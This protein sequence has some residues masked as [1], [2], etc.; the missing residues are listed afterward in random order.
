MLQ[1]CSGR[2]PEALQLPKLPSS[3]VDISTKSGYINGD[4]LLPS[5]PSKHK[6]QSIA[7]GN[8]QE[9]RR[10]KNFGRI[11]ARVKT[12]DLQPFSFSKDAGMREV[13]GSVL[14]QKKNVLGLNDQK[15]EVE[16]AASELLGKKITLQLISRGVDPET[17][18]GKKSNI[19]NLEGWVLKPDTLLADKGTTYSVHFK[20][21]EDFGTPGAFLM[22]NHHPSEFFLKSLTLDMPDKTQIHFI[23]NSWVFNEKTYEEPRVFFS[24]QVYLPKDT[25]AGLQKLRVSELNELRGDG[26]GERKDSDRQYDYDV[27]NDLGNPDKGTG[28]ARPV[29]GGSAERPYPRRCRTGR[30]PCKN[31][32]TCESA[33]VGFKETYVPR[34]E[35][36]SRE[37]LTD[38]LSSTLKSLGMD[39]IPNLE[40]YFQ[41]R[42][43]FH[44]FKEIDDFYHKG[45]DLSKIISS[46]SMPAEKREAHHKTPLEFINELTHPDL[47][48]TGTLRY[49]VPQVLQA[50][51]DAWLLD[52][53]FARQFIAGM[54]PLSIEGLK[55]FPPVSKLDPAIYGD[56]TSAITES[57][58]VDKLEGLSVKEALK[59]NKLYTADYHDAYLPHVD[60]I[61]S[62]NGKIY[63]SRMLLYLTKDGIL[64]PVAIELSL[65]P[66]VKGGNCK[67]RV[68]T[69]PAGPGGVEKTLW[70]LARTHLN[71][72]D[73]AVHQ[74]INHW[75]R[76]HACVEPFVIATFR[77][78]SV[79]HPIHTLL[80]PHFKNTLNINSLARQVLI[81]ANAIIE[82]TFPSGSYSLE[83][84]SQLYKGWRFD[85]QSLPGDL[86]KRGVAVKDP[87]AE[88][89]LR[90]SI[91]D[92][93]YAADGLDLWS[94]LKSWV[95]DYVSLYYKDDKEV[96]EDT[97]IQSWWKEIK[98]VGH[99]DKKDEPWWIE[100]KGKA[101][102][103]EAATT[104]MW[105]ASVH[106]A[107]VNF[108][109]YAYAGYVPNKPSMVKQLI[110]EEGTEEYKKLTEDS[111]KHLLTTLPKVLE[112]II[113]MSTVQV[114]SFHSSDEEYIG[115]RI[116]E[117][118]TSD[119]KV[120]EAFSKFSSKISEVEKRIEE[121]NANPK[122][123]NRH[124]PAQVP[125][126]LLMPSSGNGMTG[127]GIPNSISI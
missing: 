18:E 35:K 73:A 106:H 93:P 108:G 100:M 121:R 57:H 63:A 30:K 78:L 119:D 5:A 37:K 66:A 91:P 13:K 77:Q 39:I 64:K 56:P 127:R 74:L 14:L 114:L 59:Q 25:P 42:D 104:I 29:L 97:E 71:M 52:E 120:L 32:P 99:G 122:L 116:P 68:F 6:F 54:N 109:Q 75:L 112:G 44:S 88:H 123:K 28:Y 7:G 58:I 9:Q 90:L 115:Q 82:R 49:P 98:E 47:Q 86:L 3:P 41:N 24:N 70:M 27:Y 67:R 31:D 23:C 103:V 124:G 53:E 89:G 38:F 105:V 107:A 118:W 72:N 76:T 50:N 19:A 1:C 26:T 113:G 96:Q 79:L 11:S 69:P 94:A 20:L 8:Q 117:F 33:V 40:A 17:G 61:N 46:E 85:E 2:F 48:G 126:T 92:Y 125:Y 4:N 84:S 34:D 36:F 101:E 10:F 62:I 110:P 45:L 43:Y 60:K 95:S 21:E 83:L 12:S 51:K 102:L 111:E 15:A 55:V 22:V 87:T 81:N 80:N 16:D 65:P